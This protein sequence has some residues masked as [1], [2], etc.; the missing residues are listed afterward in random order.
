MNRYQ[1]RTNSDGLPDVLDTVTGDW[2]PFMRLET[3][4]KMADLM[5]RGECSMSGFY[6]KTKDEPWG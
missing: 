2:A 1:V 3:A 5:N 6:F 4:E